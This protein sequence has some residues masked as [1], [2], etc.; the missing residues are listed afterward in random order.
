M[1]LLP[2]NP[3]SHAVEAYRVSGEARCPNYPQHLPV[4]FTVVFWAVS[5]ET[6]SLHL[7]LNRRGA[8]FRRCV[9]RRVQAKG[10]TRA[11]ATAA[12]QAPQGREC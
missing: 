1:Y 6:R 11:R 12:S 8:G 9:I 2:G 3:F 5:F 7:Q 10:A 4:P